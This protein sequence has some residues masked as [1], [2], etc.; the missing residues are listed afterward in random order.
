PSG[1]IRLTTAADIRG[2]TPPPSAEFAEAAGGRVSPSI[3]DPA[4]PWE[5]VAGAVADHPVVQVYLPLQDTSGQVHAVVGIWRDAAPILA[6]L[7]D[8]QGQMLAVTLTAAAIAALLL[9]L[10]FRSAQD[11]ISRQTAQLLES[12]RTDALTGMRNHGALV[13]GLAEVLE[14]ARERD[15]AIGVALID[16]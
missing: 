11:R 13:T 8:A 12:T 4:Q 5:P 2:T 6:P 1:A 9:F 10:V 15:G 7:R 3:V 14:R 16:L